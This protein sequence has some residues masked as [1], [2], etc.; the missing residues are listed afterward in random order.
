MKILSRKNL[1]GKDMDSYEHQHTLS[2]CY[3]SL[4]L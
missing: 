4:A 3:F 2:F 1:F